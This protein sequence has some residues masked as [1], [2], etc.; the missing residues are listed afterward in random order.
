MNVRKLLLQ[1]F[2]ASTLAVP[3]L[4]ASNVTAQIRGWDELPG[5]MV[6][7]IPTLKCLEVVFGNVLFM[8]NAFIVLVLF[9]MFVYGS[10]IYLTSLGDQEKIQKAQGTFK[11][12]IIGLL[13]YVSAYVILKTIDILFLD[14][15]GAIFNFSIDGPIVPTPTP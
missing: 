10:F 14:G 1:T 3:F 4:A 8:S 12:A 6:D 5:C 2:A 13:L 11:F 9:V 7:G 15:N